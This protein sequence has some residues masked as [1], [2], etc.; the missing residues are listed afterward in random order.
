M[1]IASQQ[2][3]LFV[4]MDGTVTKIGHPTSISGG[5]ATNEAIE[6]TSLD[7]TDRT[8]VK[9]LS[10]PSEIT[11]DV[12]FDPSDASHITLRDLQKSGDTKQWAI[13]FSDGTDAPTYTEGW[14]F[15]D[16]SNITFEGFVTSLEF[17]FSMNDVVT[18]SV[19]VQVSGRPQ[20]EAKA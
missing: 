15:T 7:D 4:N 19:G 8:Y 17:D 5:G 9:G 12:R 10:T 14:A 18:A 20:V 16:R 13:G 11:F 1:A 2:T 3:A 6:T